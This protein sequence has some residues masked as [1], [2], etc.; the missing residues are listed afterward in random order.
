MTSL[1]NWEK[2]MKNNP[3]PYSVTVQLWSGWGWV[4]E[5]AWG[6]LKENEDI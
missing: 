1:G 3:S 5:K 6:N 4:R 2:N